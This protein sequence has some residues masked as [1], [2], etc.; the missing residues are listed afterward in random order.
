MAVR[1]GRGEL[2]WSA[3]W[4]NWSGVSFEEMGEASVYAGIV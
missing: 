3:I 4:G 1:S 2:V